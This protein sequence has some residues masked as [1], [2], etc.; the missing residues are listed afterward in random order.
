MLKSLLSTVIVLSL[1]AFASQPPLS[2]ADRTKNAMYVAL[3]SII[4]AETAPPVSKVAAA[5]DLKNRPHEVLA[6][7]CFYA[8]ALQVKLNK[9]NVLFPQSNQAA[10]P[11]RRQVQVLVELGEDSLRKACAISEANSK[12]TVQQ[13]IAHVQATIA[14]IQSEAI[15]LR[16]NIGKRHTASN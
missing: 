10:E 14:D 9:M 1:P 15:N 6:E 12:L 16:T 7:L 13:R 8:G 4:S 11:T 2:P 3:T 5:A